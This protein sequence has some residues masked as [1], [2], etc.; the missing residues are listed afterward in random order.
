MVLSGEAAQ[1]TKGGLQGQK[2]PVGA[3]PPTVNCPADVAVAASAAPVSEA[4]P[5]N[6]AAAAAA[7]LTTRCGEQQN[8]VAA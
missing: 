1:T 8:A 5:D 6:P 2:R 7:A 4:I 3:S